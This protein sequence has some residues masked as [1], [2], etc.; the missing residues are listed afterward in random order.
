[1]EKRLKEFSFTQLLE[2][3][4]TVEAVIEKLLSGYDIEITDTLPCAYVCDCN[5]ERVEKAV[6]SLGKKELAAMI[7]EGKEVEVVCDFCRTKYCFSP[8]ELM[9]L[10]QSGLKK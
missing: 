2:K 4:L 5:K 1:L 3:G 7:E 10:L 9:G 8:D 6:M